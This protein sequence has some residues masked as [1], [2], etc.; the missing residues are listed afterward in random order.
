[1][2]ELLQNISRKIKD[3]AEQS[4]EQIE[5]YG[6]VGKLKAQAFNIRKKID[7]N[8]MDIGE[9]VFDLHETGK[10]KEIKDDVTIANAIENITQLREEETAIE[11]S[12]AEEKSKGAVSEEEEHG[13]A[14]TASAAAQQ[15]TS[16]ST[17]ADEDSART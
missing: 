7:R 12:I 4:W 2:N 9:R 13:S 10:Q 17:G 11:N 14:D 1:M 6:R 16:S 3:G 8:F 5:R 15:D